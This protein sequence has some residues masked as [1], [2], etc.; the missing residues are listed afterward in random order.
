MLPSQIAA[1]LIPA[2]LYTALGA[3]FWHT[4]WH[5]NGPVSPKKIQAWE[6]I[7]I[8]IALL[9]QGLSLSQSL[10]TED[11]M[12]F[13]FALA[14]SLMMWLAVL[15]YWLESFRA[16]MDG[17]QPMVLPMAALCTALPLVFPQ[18]H[19]VA[20]VDATGFQLHFLFAMLAYSLLTLAA[21]QAIFMGYIERRLHQ[22]N[23]SRRLSSLPPLMSLETLLFRVL[24]VGFVFLTLTLV[25]GIFYADL[26]FG[27]PFKIDHKTIFAILSWLIFAVLL[28]GR[29][30][31][32]WRGRIALRWTL[33]GFVLLLLAYIGSQFVAEIVLGR[34]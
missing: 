25:S 34:I 4:R 21:L 7:A 27:Q 20:H 18:S 14:L 16:R 28:L 17:L 5:E 33:T 13:S 19:V 32:G 10:H 3:H 8:A 23:L 29:Q 30:V 9:G 2:A 24:S 1:Y 31:Y 22:R 12:R 6:R 26:I 11:G 15:M